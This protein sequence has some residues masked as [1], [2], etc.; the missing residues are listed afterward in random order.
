MT[1]SVSTMDALTLSKYDDLLSDVLLDQ[2]GLWFATRK[3]FPRYRPARISPAHIAALIRRVATR[4][5][6]LNEAISELL[7]LEHIQGFLRL[8][9]KPRLEDFRAHSQ[10]YLSMYLPEAG[11]EIGHTDRYRVATGRREAR[12]VA[13]RRYTL[14]M[15]IPLCSGS[16]AQLSPMEIAKLEREHVDFSVMWWSKKKSMCLFLGPARFV[17]HDCD[18]NC[19]FTA[20]GADAICFQA[21]RTIEPGEE[22]TTD[23]GG[24]YFGENNQ[25]CLCATCERFGR[26]WFAN[27][28]A[29]RLSPEPDVGV[30]TR[31]KG[32]RSV[33]PRSCLPRSRKPEGSQACAVCSDLCEPPL[34]QPATPESIDEPVQQ[35]SDKKLCRRC[36]RHELLFGLT[37]PDR[38]QPKRR[39]SKKPQQPGVKRR[40]TTAKPRARLPTIFDGT[41]GA[42]G[43][44]AAELFAE[45][46]RGTPVLVDPLDE[47]EKWWP[48]VIIATEDSK[49]QVRFFEDGSFAS[50]GPTEMALWDPHESKLSDLAARRALAYYEWRFLAPGRDSVSGVNAAFVLR[51]MKPDL[52]ATMPAAEQ[53]P[54]IVFDDFFVSNK[55]EAAALGS[56]TALTSRESMECI[57]PYLHMVGDLVQVVDARDGKVYKARILEADFIDNSGRLG[58]HY[59]VHY[60]GWNPKFD[61]WAPPSRIIYSD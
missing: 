22:I 40:K 21:L 25:E 2:A 15:V 24:S 26:G 61:E 43:R 19:R 39:A 6:S 55:Q 7:E 9:S 20:Q 29:G 41:L 52:A 33:T 50:C 5:T 44:S 42:L 34:E 3:M 53:E 8:K 36:A 13:T 4:E 38:P 37:W 10:R 16:I 23:Y 28:D 35:P 49:H 45:R 47:T 27:R 51:Q 46:A 57:R 14:G 32:R 18:S 54:E 31:N 30:R 58:L 59:Y 60:L 17:N 12:V 1:Q 48:G 56:Q 11:F